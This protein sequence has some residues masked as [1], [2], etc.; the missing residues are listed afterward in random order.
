M[1]L[2]KFFR[3]VI[4]SVFSVSFIYVTLVLRGAITPSLNHFFYNLLI[5]SVFFMFV[6]LGASY[7]QKV[8][9]E[10]S[11]NKIE[12]EKNKKVKKAKKAKRR[13]S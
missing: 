11:L 1:K 12:K 9:N 10:E 3:M 5:W 6:L 4:A 13:K 8:Y 2:N 7:Y